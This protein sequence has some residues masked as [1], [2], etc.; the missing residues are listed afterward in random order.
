MQAIKNDLI[1]WMMGGFI[2]LGAFLF[3]AM[4]YLR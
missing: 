2:A 3:A 4:A 1:K